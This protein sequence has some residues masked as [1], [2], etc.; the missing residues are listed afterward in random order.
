M[1]SGVKPARSAARS[2]PPETMSAPAPSDASR[3]RIAPLP[4]AL[5]A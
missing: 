4:L 2:S 1:R 5:T 3:R